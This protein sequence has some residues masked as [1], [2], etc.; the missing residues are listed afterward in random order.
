LVCHSAGM[1]E[2]RSVYRILVK[3][4]LGNGHLEDIRWEDNIKVDLNILHRDNGR[5]MKL[6]QNRV[7]RRAVVVEAVLSLT[8]GCKVGSFFFPTG[9][10]CKLLCRV[11]EQAASS[12]WRCGPMW[13]MAS[14]N[15]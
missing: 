8:N 1:R 10:P 3:R 9:T 6:Y 12:P 13:A 14:S 7:Q 4:L 11:L 5:W 15:S 2:T